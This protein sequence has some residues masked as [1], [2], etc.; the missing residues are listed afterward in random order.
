MRG[1]LKHIGFIV[2]IVILLSYLLD[3][4]YSEAFKNA[5]PRNKVQLV[6]NLKD[7]KVD[8]IFLGSSRV[9]NHID[10]DLIT[11]MTGKSCLNLGLQGSRINDGK[12]LA[13]LLEANN[14]VYEKLLMQVDYIYN[15]YDYSPSF[16]GT[17]SP[18]L[19]NT[20]F[21]EA[22]VD[23]LDLPV[24]YGL[25]FA[26]YALNDKISGVREVVLQYAKKS[27][28]LDLDNGFKPLQGVGKNVSGKFPDTI[29][30]HNEDL[31]ELLAINDNIIL[32]TAPYCQNTENRD[33]FMNELSKRYPDLINYI[34]I[35]DNEEAYFS[36]C[37]HLNI[38]G[39][40]KFTEILTKDLL[41]D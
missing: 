22:L 37:G 21:P 38:E 33:V 1:F 31:E 35:F 5:T 12:A 7:T 41:L 34:D 27:P 23:E 20:N 9:E 26:R 39:A 19:G 15:F 17:I 2:L 32:F 36:N 25:P 13:L 8:Y 29:V 28:K 40:I 16:V 10:C 24:A 18:Y 11:K 6:A 3:A 14:V 30:D 4:L